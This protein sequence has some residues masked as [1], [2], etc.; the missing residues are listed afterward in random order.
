MAGDS[1]DD[2]YALLASAQTGGFSLFATPAVLEMQCTLNQSPLASYQPCDLASLRV[3]WTDGSNTQTATIVS[4]RRREPLADS[5]PATYRAALKSHE[6]VIEALSDVEE[7]VYT[8]GEQQPQTSEDSKHLRVTVDPTY[9]YVHGDAPP[10][11]PDLRLWASDSSL[12]QTAADSIEANLFVPT[13][14][15]VRASRWGRLWPFGDDRKRFY[16]GAAY[17]CGRNP[18]V[19]Q[20]NS[21]L[22]VQFLVFPNEE[23]KVTIGLGSA[24]SGSVS[25]DRNYA[26]KT[27]VDGDQVATV[28]AYRRT[29]GST[30][31]TSTESY[32]ASTDYATSYSMTEKD[33]GLFSTRVRTLKESDSTWGDPSFKEDESTEA[34]KLSIEHKIGGQHS[35]V[36]VSGM[37]DNLMKIAEVMED[38]KKLYEG[39]PKV[40]LSIGA[41]YVL[42]EGQLIFSWGNRWP[43]HYTERDRVYYIERFLSVQG[44][45]TLIQGKVEVMF[46]VEVDPWW[47]DFYFVAKIFIETSASIGVGA[48]QVLSYTN[49]EA[50]DAALD[51]FAL[52]FSTSLEAQLGA[53]VG[54]RAFGYSLDARLALQASLK[55]E[56]RGKVG[57]KHPPEAKADLKSSGVELVGEIIVI[58]RSQRSYDF[59]PL[60]IIDEKIFFKDKVIL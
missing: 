11:H 60:H 42:F 30:T 57:F 25:V 35:E 52:D 33:Q 46:G 54:G 28:V 34:R 36:D 10:K 26:D 38:I 7:L 40:G 18:T 37:I 53:K 39:V 45:C 19:N 27:G 59:E 16:F 47:L 50:D 14:G 41:S 20:P 9:A 56:A 5:V 58:G 17:S 6:L 3:D 8:Y 22:A 12:N 31:T 15:L 23:W 32:I 48:Q 29:S 49:S 44:N 2:F 55:L 13:P 4:M 43:E 1:N 21:E 24:G 51:P